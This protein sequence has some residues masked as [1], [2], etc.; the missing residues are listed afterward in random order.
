MTTL[1]FN[2]DAGHQTVQALINARDSLQAEL[3]NVN[4]HVNTLVGTDWQGQ[5]AQQFQ[6]EFEQW[7]NQ[8]RTHLVTLDTLQQRLNSEITSWIDVASG[9]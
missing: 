1:H 7:A 4:S 6:R 9:L 2:T 3:N 8:L 5:S